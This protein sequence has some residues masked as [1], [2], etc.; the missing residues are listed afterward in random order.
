LNN[1]KLT[2]MKKLTCT[3]LI[4]IAFLFSVY[5]NSSYSQATSAP[6]TNLPGAGTD[7]LGWATGSLGTVNELT[8][9]NDEAMSI[10]FYTSSGGTLSNLRMWIYDNAAPATTQGFIGIGDMG[11]SASPVLPYSLLHSYK[12]GNTDVYHQFSNDNTG[13]GGPPTS[14]SQGLQVGIHFDNPAT[15]DFNGPNPPYTIAEV[16]QWHDAPMDFYLNEV[17]SPTVLPLRMRISYGMGCDRIGTGTAKLRELQ[18]L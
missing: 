15:F 8:I 16:R 18:K 17:S 10:N 1:N 3:T 2:I 7:F 11:T 12:S 5:V 14:S 13:G 9:N 6:G 4:T